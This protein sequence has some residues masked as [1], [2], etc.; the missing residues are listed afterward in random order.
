MWRKEFDEKVFFSESENEEGVVDRK[1]TLAERC[2]NLMCN[3]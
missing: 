1:D 3:R 2:V